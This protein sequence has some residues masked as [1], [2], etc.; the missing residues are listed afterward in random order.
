M[1][2]KLSAVLKTIFKISDI[3]SASGFDLQLF[4]ATINLAP[5]GALSILNCQ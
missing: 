3:V 1:I 4:E 2:R 5:I